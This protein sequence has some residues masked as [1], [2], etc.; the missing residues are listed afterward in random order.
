MI[1]LSI[2]SNP[3]LVHPPSFIHTIITLLHQ[4]I[5]RPPWT[6]HRPTVTTQNTINTTNPIMTDPHRPTDQPDKNTTNTTN[7]PIRTSSG[8]RRRGSPRPWRRC[9]TS[10]PRSTTPVRVFV[11]RMWPFVGWVVSWLGGWVGSWMVGRSIDLCVPSHTDSHTHQLATN[12]PPPP[13]PT[14]T[15]TPTPTTIPTN[16][17]HRLRP[18]R[19]PVAGQGGHRGR[20][21][22]D[23][24]HPGAHVLSRQGSHRLGLLPQP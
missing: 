13:T 12:H 4:P 24:G 11:G 16:V 14:R 22:E 23:A 7:N 20:G 10:S 17:P 2:Q 9:R 1:N 6:H 8:A 21:A 3:S 15:H 18:R 19:L 5:D